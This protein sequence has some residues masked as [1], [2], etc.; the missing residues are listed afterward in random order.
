MNYAVATGICLIIR[1]AIR[2]AI[3]CYQCNSEYDPRCG[4]PFDP[5]SLGT[6]NCS[7]QPRLEH[8]N[9]LEPVLCR[10]ISQRGI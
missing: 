10:K 5:Y 3:I 4:D 8:L 7:F 1:P 9:H 2:E 6:V